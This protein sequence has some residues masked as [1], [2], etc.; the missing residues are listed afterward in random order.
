MKSYTLFLRD[1]PLRDDHRSENFSNKIRELF[2]TL[3]IP[4]SND[5]DFV[6]AIGGDGTFIRAVTETNFNP[7][8]I[9]AGVNTGTLGFLQTMTE[10]ELLESITS[11]KRK[12]QKLY[13]PLIELFYSD[14]NSE[15][16]HCINEL[17]VEGVHGKKLSFKEYV[18]GQ[19][20]QKVSASAVCIAASTCGDTAFSMNAGGAIDFSERKNQLIRTLVVPIRNAM[21]ERFL[22]NPI[23]SNEVMLHLES[24]AQVIIDGQE[25]EKTSIEKIIVSYSK[26]HYIKTMEV[27]PYSK[28]DT[29]RKK[30]LGY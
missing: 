25:F 8:K 9:Y 17:V 29:I 26:R 11:K 27:K 12:F 22:P 4:E 30:I 19:F 28:I 10:E 7:K 21:Y 2:S 3:N 24:D 14:G 13:V 23:I 6:I 20:Y 1:D 16:H 15:L 5:G 18:N